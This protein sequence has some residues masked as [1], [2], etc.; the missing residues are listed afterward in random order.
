MSGYMDTEQVRGEEQR[1]RQRLANL[2]RGRRTMARNR[3]AEKRA[4]ARAERRAAR[5][6]LRRIA[7]DARALGRAYVREV[8]R[9]IHVRDPEKSKQA[10]DRADQ[11]QS[12]I[13]RLGARRQEL[14]RVLK[15]GA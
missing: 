2:E 13:L 6:E 5:A 15:S 1:E 11:A 14:E 10:F 12:T 7:V 3:E 4:S 8:K 9:G